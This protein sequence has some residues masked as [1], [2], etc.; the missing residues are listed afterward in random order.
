MNRASAIAETPDFPWLAADDAAGVARV[1]ADRGLLEPEEQVRAAPRAGEGNM[2]LTLRVATNRRTLIVKQARPWVEK[3][4]QIAA[5]WNRFE[6]ELAFYEWVAGE[7]RLADRMPRLLAADRA[8]CLI[9]LQD[10]APAADLTTLY[11]GDL[12]TTAE[13]EQLAAFLA[14]LHAAGRGIA[15]ARWANRDMRALNHEHM[16]R[17][18]LDEANGLELDR[19]EPGL[20]DAARRLQRDRA[21]C[22]QVHATGQRYLAD[23]M[24]LLHGDYFPGSWL[25]TASGVFV[26]DPEF[27][28]CGDPEFDLGV[29]LAHCALAAQ[30]GDVSR[31]FLEAY[32]A[33]GGAGDMGQAAAYAACEV[34]RRLIGVAQL[35]L[36]PSTG[37]RR[38]LLERSRAALAERRLEPLLA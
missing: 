4:D 24:V 5:P 26:I 29:C 11:S 13:V 27:C 37:R 30:P 32:R 14:G 35:P 18:P 1:L 31:G 17:L 7:P 22:E 8:A 38:E 21:Y 10:L 20:T 9:V 16:Y 25:R 33:S 12:L 19:F 6:Y 3:Y 36:A 34:M 23:G 2:N 15:P 28:Y